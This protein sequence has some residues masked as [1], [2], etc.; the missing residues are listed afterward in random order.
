MI[1]RCIAMYWIGTYEHEHIHRNIIQFINKDPSDDKTIY[2]AAILT[3]V[4]NS[5]LQKGK[6]VEKRKQDRQREGILHHCHTLTSETWGYLHT[7]VLSLWPNIA[8]NCKDCQVGHWSH[9]NWPTL[10]HTCY[11]L[12][13]DYSN[14]QTHENYPAHKQS[15]SH[16]SEHRLQDEDSLLFMQKHGHA[17]PVES[18]TSHFLF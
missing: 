7:P 6:L 13:R 12:L 18:A 11:R 5:S 16:R 3:H 1:L 4:I 17:S 2:A 15:N 8:N 10:V 9:W 14:C